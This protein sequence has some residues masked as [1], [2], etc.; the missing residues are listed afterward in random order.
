MIRYPNGKIY[1]KK[2]QNSKRKTNIELS[3]SSANRGMGLE[4]DIN[5]TNKYYLE[6]NIALIYKRPTPVK[7]LKCDYSK[8]KRIVDAY[9]EKQSTTDY[10]GV[11]RGRY[12]DFEAKSTKNKTS[13]PLAN[14]TAH[15]IE[16]LKKVKAHNGIAFFIVEFSSIQ[17]TYLLDATIVIKFIDKEKRKSIPYMT[18]LSNGYLIDKS[19]NPRLDYIKIVNK[20]YF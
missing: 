1:L 9:F 20:L 8:G 16:H 4:N 6:N 15:Q 11:Y 3:K 18:F 12:I 5:L 2:I 19:Y 10:N 14:I 17:E 13:F 7:V